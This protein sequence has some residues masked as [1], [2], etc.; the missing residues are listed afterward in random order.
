MPLPGLG[1]LLELGVAVGM[2]T[3]SEV[4]WNA[5]VVEGV[6]APPSLA[7]ASAMTTFSDEIDI[8]VPEASSSCAGVMGGT[9]DRDRSIEDLAL[10]AA[11]A[12]ARSIEVRILSMDDLPA[13]TCAGGSKRG[14]LDL[15]SSE[16]SFSLPSISSF[17]CSQSSGSS[18]SASKSAAARQFGQIKIG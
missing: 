8:A 12:L 3:G 1:V 13:S 2:G 11:E 18:T 16:V 9:A 14:S 15:L 7:P 4:A 10:S 6:L 5:S 17:S